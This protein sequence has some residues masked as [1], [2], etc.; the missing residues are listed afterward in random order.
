MASLIARTLA[1][2]LATMAVTSCLNERA[3]AVAAS[4]DALCPGCNVVLVSFDTLRADHMSVYGYERP[5]TPNLEPLAG[6]SVVFERAISQ[7]PWTLPAHGSM[8]S[9]LYP[10]RLGVLRYPANRRLPD[11]NPMVAEVFTRAGYATG[12][13]TGGGFVSGHYGFARGFDVYST[14]GR[15]FEHS[16]PQ[17]EAWLELNQ[18]RKFFLFVHGYDAHRPYF[19]SRVNK[20]AVGLSTKLPAQVSGYCFRE[21]RARPSDEDLE[22]IIHYYDA[23]IRSGDQHLAPLFRK[24][25]ALGLM[26]KT[27]VIVTSDHGEE[28]YEHGNCDH[29][30]FVYNEVVHVPLMIYVPGLTPEGRRHAGQVPASIAI[31]RTV[32]DLVG[33]E[34]NMPGV[35]LAPVLAGKEQE[36]PVIYSHADTKA[37]ALGSR[38]EVVAMTR[39]QYKL[40]EYLDE[41]S[42]E[43]YD[44]FQDPA[45]TTLLPEGSDAYD[46]RNTVRAWHG[47]LEELP[48]PTEK[49]PKVQ[50]DE[51]RKARK[52]RK[53]EKAKGEDPSEEDS[54]G[55]PPT[56]V[57]DSQ[58]GPS[59]DEAGSGASED[60]GAGGSQDAED[61][62]D[63]EDSE[64][65]GFGDDVPDDVR[66]S[67]KALGYIED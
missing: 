54:G 63:A 46:M 20:A 30:R 33:L 25:E 41:G 37:G 16:V 8:F 64:D 14:N 38:G 21:N 59:G 49:T 47:S 39:D 32:L 55:S 15:H 66:E 44:I 67:L 28:F 36:F 65:E 1:V 35:S 4:V 56:T 43:G 57:G 2:L 7:A 19:S 58:G 10:G 13:F 29:V 51:D 52:R 5:T 34:H 42:S 50:S 9:G 40:L 11:V 12:G 48:K 24:L 22:Q 60:P 27:I 18:K 53:D 17:A 23:A 45:E 6:R 31:A 61:A 62:D 3:P 26:E